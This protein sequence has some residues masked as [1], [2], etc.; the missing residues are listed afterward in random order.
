MDPREL[1]DEE[2]DVLRDV[3]QWWKNNRDWMDTG[4]I[5]RLDAAVRVGDVEGDLD[6]DGHPGLG[7]DD[8]DGGVAENL[9]Y[10]AKLRALRRKGA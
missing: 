3:S 5:L 7:G 1:T 6:L 2:A 4:D 9:T 10:V 8:A